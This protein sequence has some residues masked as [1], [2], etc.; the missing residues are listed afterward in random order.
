MKSRKLPIYKYKIKEE[1]GDSDWACAWDE[2]VDTYKAGPLPQ[3]YPSNANWWLC[4][5][6]H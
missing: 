2:Y 1:P 4:S 5:L 3:S 6:A